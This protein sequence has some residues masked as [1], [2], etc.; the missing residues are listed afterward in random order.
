MVCLYEL[1]K[2]SVLSICA[3]QN[4]QQGNV[5]GLL[6]FYYNKILT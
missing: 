6:G 4:W 5:H 3:E 2:V 1:W